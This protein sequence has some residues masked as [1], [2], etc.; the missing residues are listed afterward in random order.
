MKVLIPL[1]YVP[2]M[3]RWKPLAALAVGLLV[4]TAVGSLAGLVGAVAEST[5]A[6]ATVGLVA[7]VV[8]GLSA[9]GSAPSRWLSTPYWGR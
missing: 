5:A 8:L 6:L 2:A 3:N 9:A 4:V 1:A 7:L